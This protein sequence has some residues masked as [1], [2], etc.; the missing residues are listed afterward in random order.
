LTTATAQTD[1]APAGGERIAAA[2]RIEGYDLARAMAILGMV[3]VHFALVM[4]T[5]HLERGWLAAVVDFLD[6]RAAATF[7]VLAGVGVTLMSRGAA[8]SGDA[9]TLAA[10]RGTLVRRGLFLLTVGF[11]NLL[12]WPGDILRVY[13]VTLLVAASFVAAPNRWLWAMSLAFVAGFLLLIGLVD[14][15]DH[16]D[17]ETMEYR[18][19]WTAMGVL[20][21]LFYDGFRSVYPWAGL[22][23]FGMWLGRQDLRRPAVRRRFLLGGVG[24]VVLTELASR[25]LQRAALGSESGMSRE[26]VEA[27]FGTASM[28]PLPLFL[29]SAVG[30]AVAVITACVAIAERFGASLPVRALVATGQLAFTWYVAHILLGLGAVVELGFTEGLPLSVGVGTGLAFF[31]TAAVVSLLWR[32][33]FRHGPLEWLMRRFAG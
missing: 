15:S 10:V 27:L 9:A 12:I 30:T 2:G 22:L 11:V 4:S 29:L 1:S 16:W 14:Y 31:A 6:G 33:R 23:F 18:D 8:A 19:L 13:G 21:N 17:W 26:D 20:R 32:R 25:L 5:D 7:V 3:V 28:P 24:L